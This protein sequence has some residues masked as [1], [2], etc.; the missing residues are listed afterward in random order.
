MLAAITFSGCGL[1][2]GVDDFVDAPSGEGG[3][4]PG[5]GDSC[6]A[7]ERRPCYGGPSDTQGIGMCL[8]GTQECEGGRFGE[9]VGA[10]LPVDEDCDAVGDENCDGTACSEVIW[11]NKY[12]GAPVSFPTRIAIAPNGDVAI[13]GTYGEGSMN[14]GPDPSTE[15]PTPAAEL[16]Y[17]IA[18]FD[19]DGKHIWS[20]LVEPTADSYPVVAFDPTG[21]LTMLGRFKDNLDLGGPTLMSPDAP[22]LFAAKFT[23]TGEHLW[24]RAF[25]PQNGDT[26]PGGIGTTTTGDVVITGRFSGEI[27]LG[28]EVLVNPPGETDYDA[29]IARLGADTGDLLWSIHIGDQPG[30]LM[31]EGTNQRTTDLAVDGSDR[32]VVTGTF[33][34]QIDFD[35]S[36]SE[37]FDTNTLGFVVQYGADGAHRWHTTFRGEG[38]VKPSTIAADSAGNVVIGG[39]FGGSV[40]F[41]GTSGLGSTK[42]TSD[43]PDSDLFLVHLTSA[44]V[45]SWS[46]QLGDDTPQGWDQDLL[47]AAI[48][49]LGEVTFVGG[50]RGTADFGTGPLTSNDTDWFLAK[51]DAM[52]NALWNRRYGDGAAFQAATDV[53][54]DPTSRAVV[55]AGVSDGSLALVDPPLVV[56]AVGTALAKLSP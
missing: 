28:G 23:R 39:L 9:C 31:G 15:L 12:D 47:G 1:A 29:F 26:Y 2:L 42:T 46:K 50:F 17:F 45:H 37:Y 43:P 33:T 48:D 11:A 21:N 6:A 8:P 16:A 24:S 56:Q 18:V 20:R 51:Y 10:V 40:E 34:E 7:D 53:A 4:G 36:T 25:H 30:T 22:A 44:G 19:K 35:G 54:V 27:D 32:I 5:G 38:T 3:Q 49:S 13:V 52:G 14:F 55:V 41:Q